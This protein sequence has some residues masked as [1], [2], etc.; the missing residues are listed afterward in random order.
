MATGLEVY[1]S[2][3]S[4]VRAAVKGIFAQ[5]EKLRS[6]REA[7]RQKIYAERRADLRQIDTEERLEDRQI[8][9]EDRLK[10]R[11]DEESLSKAKADA[12]RLGLSTEGSLYEIEGRIADYKEKEPSR[13]FL[14]AN[15]DIIRE[16]QLID[17]ETISLIE[18]GKLSKEKLSQLQANLTPIITAN[19]N[20]Q[21]ATAQRNTPDY[22]YRLE[23]ATMQYQGLA[24]QVSEI[25]GAW[26]GDM[27]NRAVKIEKGPEYFKE[28]GL[29]T[30][31]NDNL[32]GLLDSEGKYPLL[33]KALTTAPLPFIQNNV[34]IDNNGTTIS[35]MATS[36]RTTLLDAWK[37]GMIEARNSAS[38]Q[39]QLDYWNKELDLKLESEKRK[40]NAPRL[41]EM[42]NKMTK[43]EVEF[44]PLRRWNAMAN[45]GRGGQNPPEGT[46]ENKKED[47]RKKTA[48]ELI[49]EQQ[50]INQSGQD[51]SQT[52]PLVNMGSEGVVQDDYI[53]PNTGFTL[54]P[55]DAFAA[56]PTEDTAPPVA[57][58]PPV[59]QQPLPYNVD[60]AKAD[61]IDQQR[62]FPES[63]AGY[64]LPPQAPRSAVVPSDSFPPGYQPV[65]GNM[66]EYNQAWTNYQRV[67][68][69]YETSGD[70]GYARAMAALRESAIPSIQAQT[71]QQP[72]GW[73]VR[74]MYGENMELMPGSVT[75]NLDA[76]NQARYS[77][78]S[79]LPSRDDELPV[80]N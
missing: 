9:Q 33:Y 49:Q 64:Q 20:S 70:T 34:V 8:R 37:K 67:T 16:Q 45:N 59:Q 24:K 47:A 44:E 32:K 61:A 28:A 66:D 55:V 73:D 51:Q 69:P 27:V 75:A 30:V 36:D 42:R 17:D 48:A 54:P 13:A 35:K 25:E 80:R 65:T 38:D 52:P 72:I 79:T 53:D 7:E 31:S 76:A 39:A 43:L 14:M 18:N 56:M 5:Q 22:Q 6:E 50:Q 12:S 3:M 71:G 60:Q 68:K 78:L 19:R 23:G 77:N 1:E 2:T 11:R 21:L 62:M 15:I 46:K 41:Q 63:V 10:K 4:P 74:Q 40:L 57:Q 26:L 58:T 29:F